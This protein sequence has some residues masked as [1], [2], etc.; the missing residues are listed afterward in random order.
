MHGFRNA[1]N[2]RRQAACHLRVGSYFSARNTSFHLSPLFPFYVGLSEEPAPNDGHARA[3]DSNDLTLIGQSKTARKE[4]QDVLD[5]YPAILGKAGLTTVQTREVTRRRNVEKKAFQTQVFS[6][7]G[8]LRLIATRAKDVDLLGL[9]TIGRTAFKELRP[10]LQAGVGKQIMAA[11]QTRATELADNGLKA[12]HLT[13]AS[14]ALTTF[15]TGLPDT[16]TLLDARKNANAMYEEVHDAQM[17]QIYELDLA[18]AVFE[19]LNPALFKEYKQ[20]RAILDTGKKG[21]KEEG[22]V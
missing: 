1:I 15:T 6:I 16:Q 14:D 12:A 11:A 22:G 19:T 2:W 5:G 17:Q 7:L 21:K 3:L 13:T 10:E 9:V 18:M 20:A 8:P 4:A